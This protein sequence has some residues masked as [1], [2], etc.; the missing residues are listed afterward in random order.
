MCKTSAVTSANHTVG[1]GASSQS[2]SAHMGNC[3]HMLPVAGTRSSLGTTDIGRLQ[4][5]E[6]DAYT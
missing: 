1:R 5:Q 6:D 3:P 2:F 4:V